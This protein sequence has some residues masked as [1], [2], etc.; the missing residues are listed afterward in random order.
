MAD[1]GICTV[2]CAYTRDL[3][4]TPSHKRRTSAFADDVEPRGSSGSEALALL[5][6]LL[7]IHASSWTSMRG[8]T[9]RRLKLGWKEQEARP[10][11]SPSPENSSAPGLRGGAHGLGR[12]RQVVGDHRLQPGWPTWSQD[13]VLAELL[14]ERDSREARHKRLHTSQARDR[15][16][17]QPP[18]PSA[19]P[20]RAQNSGLPVGSSHGPRR[21]RSRD[22]SPREWSRG[23][24]KG[25]R[26]I[27]LSRAFPGME[28]LT[29]VG[30]LL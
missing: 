30:G 27:L 21:G 22:G 24:R 6:V 18:K 16:A 17:P 7:G 12:R 4:T 29:I 28:G 11:Q 10:D 14:G 26:S 15:A 8:Q 20:L 19:R 2:T 3:L 13:P 5:T 23:G 1:V 9:D 25:C